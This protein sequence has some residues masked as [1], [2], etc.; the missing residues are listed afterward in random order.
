MHFD[1]SIRLDRSDL[2]RESGKVHPVFQF[3]Q[4]KSDYIA[5]LGFFCLGKPKF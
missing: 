4:A 3:Q 5:V 1:E 2:V